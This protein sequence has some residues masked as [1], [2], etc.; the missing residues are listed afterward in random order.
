MKSVL[1][2]FFLIILKNKKRHYY[3]IIKK[4]LVFVTLEFDTIVIYYK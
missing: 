1:T 2:E 3:Y 4:E